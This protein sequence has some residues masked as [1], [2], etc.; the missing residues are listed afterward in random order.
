MKLKFIS[1]RESSGR[2]EEENQQEEAPQLK[3]PEMGGG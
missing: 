2:V 3:N 1:Y